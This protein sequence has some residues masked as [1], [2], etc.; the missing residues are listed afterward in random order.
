MAKELQKDSQTWKNLEAAFAGESQAAIKYQYFASRAKKDGYEQISAIFNETSGNEKEHAKIWFKLLHGGA[1][2]DTAS[3]LEA[4][5]QGE[6]MEW[7]SMYVDFAKVARDE[8]YDEI[9]EKFDEVAAIEK[10]HEARYL[11]LHNEVENDIV[12]KNDDVTVWKCRNCGY[13]FTGEEAPE[14][15]PVCAH[16]RAYFERLAENY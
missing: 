13:V 5:A 16:P 6:N 8:G 11:K 3:N 12:F 4:A 2:A 9:A 7:T 1:V 10:S 15:C 14:V